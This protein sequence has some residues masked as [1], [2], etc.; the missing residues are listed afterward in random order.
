MI[1]TINGGINEALP[2]KVKLNPTKLKK[3]TGITQKV[4]QAH[5]SPRLYAVTEIAINKKAK[6]T[7]DM[8]PLLK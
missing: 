4:Y 8:P 1:I 2:S 3:N 5:F 7:S 6:P